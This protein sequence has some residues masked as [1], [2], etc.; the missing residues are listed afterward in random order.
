M[1]LENSIYHIG[2]I[3]RQRFLLIIRLPYY[4]ANTVVKR[5]L[6]CGPR[7][8]GGPRLF[9]KLNNFSQQISKVYIRK[10]SKSEIENFKM[11]CKSEGIWNW[12]LK[13]TL[14]NLPIQI[15][16]PIFVYFFVCELNKIFCDLCICLLCTVCVFFVYYFQVQIVEMA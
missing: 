9:R 13:I 3:T 15:Q 2:Q 12:R 14:V 5:F 1:S 11:L 10:K 6:T 7:T 16:I 4:K 8:P